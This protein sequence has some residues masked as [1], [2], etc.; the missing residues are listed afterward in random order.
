MKCYEIKH[1][2]KFRYSC[3]YLWT[4]LI[5]NKKYVG[6]TQDLGERFVRYNQNDFN[7]Y[8][9]KAVNKYGI[10]N[11]EI[12]ILE[13][14]V[15]KEKLNEREQHWMDYFQ[16]YDSDYGYNICKIAGSCRGVKRS[17]EYKQAC[18][19]RMLDR[20]ANGEKIWLGRTH[21]KET[22]E[23]MSEKAK[24]L[25]ENH[26]EIWSNHYKH[27]KKEKQRTSEFFKEYWK[28]HEHSWKGK[29]HTPETKKKMSEAMNK[30]PNRNRR[31]RRVECYTLE[32]VYICTYASA[33]EA[34]RNIGHPKGASFILRCAN[35]YKNS[36]YGFKWKDAG[37]YHESDNI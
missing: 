21:S 23:L 13:K 4:N 33:S 28:T 17:E 11:F 8:M 29:N 14:D 22:K 9:K 31:M 5:N 37:L 3:I 36:A 25:H 16:A 24:H 30:N 18:S 6:Q 27:T 26:P 32:G 2:K 19:E 12:T 7:D 10:D 20:I 15:P 35:G 1:N 34:A